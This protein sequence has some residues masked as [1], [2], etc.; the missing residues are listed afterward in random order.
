[1]LERVA[2]FKNLKGCDGGHRG[3]ATEGLKGN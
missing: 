2:L 1:M 3:V